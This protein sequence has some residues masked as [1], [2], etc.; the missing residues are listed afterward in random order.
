[1]RIAILLRL[2]TMT[3]LLLKIFSVGKGIHHSP[4]KLANDRSFNFELTTKE[5]ELNENN[6]WSENPHMGL[7]KVWLMYE[8]EIKD[9]I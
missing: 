1:M 4:L 9:R 7:P 5:Q 8:Q 3:N 2:R 6:I